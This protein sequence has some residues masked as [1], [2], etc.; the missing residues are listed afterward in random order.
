M[1]NGRFFLSNVFLIS[2]VVSAIWA[3]FVFGW[4]WNWIPDPDYSRAVTI[5]QILGVRHFDVSKA[6]AVCSVEK[7]DEG[8]A[9]TVTINVGGGC[10]RKFDV[11]L[12]R[13]QVRR[14]TG[15][16]PSAT[17]TY[18]RRVYFKDYASDG[19]LDWRSPNSGGKEGAIKTFNSLSVADLTKVDLRQITLRLTPKMAKLLRP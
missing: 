14:A 5:Q 19:V 9:Y 16:K 18:N 15:K 6:H 10:K 7:T 11:T 12:P 2:L 1:R 3:L 8:K 4:P 17:F 13:E